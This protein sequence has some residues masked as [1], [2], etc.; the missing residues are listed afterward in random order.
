MFSKLYSM[1]IKT[2]VGIMRAVAYKDAICLLEFNDR[3]ELENELTDLKKHFNAEV[4]EAE[5]EPLLL[6][7]SEL[8][9]YF[10]GK[11]HHFS[12]KTELI[13]TDFQKKV[14]ES[15]TLIPFG[16][17]R[18]YKDQS[19]VLGDLKA[20][21]AVASANGKNKLAIIIPCHR[22]IGSDGNL[23]GYAGGLERK[24]FLLNLE[25]RI[26]GPADLFTT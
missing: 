21:R 6:L 3:P 22:V 4:V 23:T 11:K 26:A 2:P 10:A 8:K 17:T 5:N 7:K 25:R 15:L 9:D 1:D 24:R 19:V 18:T 14:W 13:G 16:E 12:V 20:I